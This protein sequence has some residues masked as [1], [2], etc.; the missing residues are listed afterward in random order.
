MSTST[1]RTFRVLA[2]PLA[3]LA[4][5]LTGVTATAAIVT[6]LAAAI[7]PPA[8]D[9]QP[10]PGL[11]APSFVVDP[12]WPTVPNG[13]VL[14]EV[15]SIAARGDRIWVLHRPRSIPEDQRARSA[16]PVLEFDRSG[17][18]LGSWGGPADGYD[19]PEREHGIWVDAAG[20]VWISGNGGWPR[21]AADGSTDDMILK[22]TRDGDLVMQIGKR[23]QSGGNTDTVNVHQPA[24]LFVHETANEL[25]VADGYGNQRIIVYDTGSGAFRRM[26]GAFGNAPVDAGD[27]APGPGGA[28]GGATGSGAPGS[29][30]SAQAAAPQFN[31]VHAVKVSNDGIV[32]VADRGNQRVQWFTTAGEYLAQIVI[33]GEQP[34]APAGFAF[35]PDPEQRLLYIVE[36]ANAR[37]LVYDRASMTQIGVF[38]SRSAAPGGMDIAHHIAMDSR[39]NFYTAEIVNNRRA[40]KFVPR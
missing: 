23:G 1:L 40:Q 21:P 32:Y 20:Y 13:W 33:E 29:A 26:W 17:Q 15:T 36:S 10:A 7:W 12:A 3:A 4:T 35:S 39:G 8:A 18:L 38:G 19:W 14:G 11:S 30:V 27:T 28:G 31:L 37:V 2:A 34:P 9:A 16:P 6:A 25:Y 5:N 22:F 24:D